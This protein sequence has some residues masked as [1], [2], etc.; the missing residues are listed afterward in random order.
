MINYFRRARNYSLIGGEAITIL[1]TVVVLPL[2][3]ATV[4]LT[5]FEVGKSSPQWYY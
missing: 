3:M 1:A 2:A 5:G 4:K